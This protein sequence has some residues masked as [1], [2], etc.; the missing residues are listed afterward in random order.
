MKA[1]TG[2]ALSL[3]SLFT[4]AGTLFCCAL[5]ALFVALGAGAAFAGLTSAFPQII[6]LGAHK[7]WLFLAGGGFLAAAFVL[8]RAEPEACEITP[9]SPSACEETRSWSRPLLYLSSI[10]YVTGAF[11]AYA[12]PLLFT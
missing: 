1:L 9:G 10:L 8:G 5:P 7:T 4:S 2:K 12:A 3:L 6:W 11:F